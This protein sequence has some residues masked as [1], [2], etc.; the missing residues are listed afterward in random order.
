MGV[1]NWCNSKL[2]NLMRM[3]QFWIVSS[4]SGLFFFGGGSLFSPLC[5]WVFCIHFTHGW[6]R[7]P[8]GINSSSSQVRVHSA[9]AREERVSNGGENKKKQEIRVPCL[10]CRPAGLHQTYPLHHLHTRT[11]R[12]TGSLYHTHTC[13]HTLLNSVE[14]QVD[15]QSI[16]PPIQSSPLETGCYPWQ[17]HRTADTCWM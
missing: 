11:R 15:K 12:H 14:R 16:L 17:Q 13:S 5:V 8:L 7:H 9:G 10:P 6:F 4:S 3:Q 1:F 2:V